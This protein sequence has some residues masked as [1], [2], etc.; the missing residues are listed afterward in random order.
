[1]V[2]G[3]SY[4]PGCRACPDGMILNGNVEIFFFCMGHF[5]YW[6]D[7]RGQDESGI[8]CDVE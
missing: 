1:M 8:D 3:P 6:E 4:E 5:I 7:Q 2:A